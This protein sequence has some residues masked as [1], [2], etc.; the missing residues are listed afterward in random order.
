M[1]FIKKMRKVT[2][3]IIDSGIDNRFKNQFKCKVSGIGVTLINNE[4]KIVEDYFDENGHGTLTASVI[5]NECPDIEFFIIKILDRKL[6]GN[7]ECLIASLEYLL[8]KDVNIINMSLVVEKNGRDS[9][10]KKICKR[11]NDQGKILIAAVENGSKK[12]IP[13]I[14]ST[15]I[16]VEGRK[17]KQNFDFMFSSNKRINCVIRS[18]P[19]LYYQKK[20]DY[21]MYGDC[22]SFAA[23]KLSGKLARILRKQPSNDN[24]KVKKLLRKESKLFVWTVPLLNLFKEYPVFRDNNI[25]YDPIKLNKLATNIAV[26]F[27]V[28]NISDIYSYSLYSSKISQKKEFAYRFLR[29]LEE[30]YG[31]VCENYSV[32]ER[33]D[34]ISIYSVYKFLKERYKW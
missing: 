23:A 9:R 16:A 28:E 26:F 33:N 3:A 18:E 34:F 21:V 12:S 17:L 24:S 4:I 6:E 22:N 5:I 20:D 14:Y 29:F 15:V 10:L 8:D 2:I 31:F 25:I 19:H 1:A 30:K 7:I 11:L 32:F 13:A 27:S